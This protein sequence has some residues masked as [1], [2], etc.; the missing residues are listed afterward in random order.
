M[1]NELYSLMATGKNDLLWRSVFDCVSQQEVALGQEQ[2]FA[3]LP[4]T[5]NS[6]TTRCQLIVEPNLKQAQ[7][8]QGEI[9]KKKEDGWRWVFCAKL[10]LPCPLEKHM[11]QIR[12][13]PHGPPE[14]KLSLVNYLFGVEQRRGNKTCCYPTSTKHSVEWTS[15]RGS[16]KHLLCNK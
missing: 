6:E 3:M 8:G 11:V 16:S 7:A 15:E 10:S 5:V 13:A 4:Y 14:V 1:E 2:T 9:Y 12:A